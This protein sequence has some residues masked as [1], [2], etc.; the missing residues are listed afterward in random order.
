MNGSYPME[1]NDYLQ[2]NLDYWSKGYSA[3]NV[4]S[5]VFR[6]YGRILRHEFGID[7]SNGETLL[8]FGCGQGAACRFFHSKG[9]QVHGVDISEADIA[10]CK[11]LVPEAQNRFKVISPKPTR[12]NPY[13]RKS[14]N[15][16]IGIQSL[17]YFS[18]A[19]F[20]ILIEH[21]L[22]QMEEGGFIYATMVSPRHK[23][24]RHSRAHDDGLRVVEF[25]GARYSTKDYYVNFTDNEDHLLDKFKAFEPLHIGQYSQ[26]Y[27]SDE[28]EEHHLTFF[29]RKR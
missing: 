26:K 3:E 25:T 29:G 21:L 2:K 14:F 17:Y 9:F 24:Y 15:I 27:R 16:I 13:F 22:D 7:G 20:K 10:I 18:N 6:M 1:Q 19:D 12:G 4:E 23:F 11:K 8:D 28:A 5:W